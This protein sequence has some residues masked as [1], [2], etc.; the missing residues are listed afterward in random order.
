MRIAA[1]VGAE[2]VSADSMQVYRGMDIGTAKPTPEERARVPHHLV[3]LV[4][5]EERFTVAEAQIAG[6]RRHCR[7]PARR[8]P[9]PDRWGIGT[10]LSGPRG[11]LPLQ[12][13]R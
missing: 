9:C 2:I 8:D 3:D 11:P 1:A 7:P 10:P 4:E 13:N 5:P 6:P 12:P